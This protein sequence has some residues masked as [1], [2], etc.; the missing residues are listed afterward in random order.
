M[1]GGGAKN[2]MEGSYT[3]RFP[4]THN[5]T[6]SDSLLVAQAEQQTFGAQKVAQ[7]GFHRQ[8]C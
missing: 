6:G 5:C 7:A 2:N 8:A 1:V 4:R 3:F